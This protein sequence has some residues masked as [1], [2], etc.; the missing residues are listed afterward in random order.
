MST[1]SI[2]ALIDHSLLKPTM[3]IAELEEGCHQAREWQVAT[4]CLLPHFVARAAE[5][6]EGSGVATTTVVSFPHGSVSLRAKLREAEVALDDGARELDVVVNLS[7]IRS[8][9]WDAVRDE[10]EGLTRCCHERKSKLKLIFETCFL[11]REEKVRLCRLASEAGVDWVKTSTGFGS[12]G[13]TA[14]DVRLMREHCPPSVQVK[15][16]GGIVSLDEALLFRQ[17]G[18]TRIG[19]SR[20]ENILREEAARLVSR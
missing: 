3:T 20:T 2:A 19:T 7:L 16:S 6:L 15:A 11:D 12:S 9:R 17:L 13:A 10:V 14:D 4:V 8:G 5:L 18:A 1:P